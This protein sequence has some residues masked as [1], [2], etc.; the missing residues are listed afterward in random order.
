M[1]KL[2]LGLPLVAACENMNVPAQEAGEP[3]PSGITYEDYVADAG[4]EACTEDMAARLQLWV[5]G[6]LDTAVHKNL[7]ARLCDLD[8]TYYSDFDQDGY[9]ENADCDDKYNGFHPG[10]REVCDDGL[11]SDCDGDS[12]FDEPGCEWNSLCYPD[13]DGDGYVALSTPDGFLVKAVRPE[14]DA[15]PEGT[16][17][18]NHTR[19]TEDCDDAD[20][21]TYPGAQENFATY[22]DYNCDGKV[23]TLLGEVPEELPE[24]AIYKS[25]ASIESTENSPKDC[26]WTER[27]DGRYTASLAENSSAKNVYAHCGY[28]GERAN[29][30]ELLGD[31]LGDFVNVDGNS[32][33]VRLLGVENRHSPMNV[34]GFDSNEV[35]VTNKDLILNRLRGLYTA[36]EAVQ[37]AVYAWAFPRVADAFVSLDGKEQKAFYDVIDHAQDYL[38]TVDVAEETAWLEALRAATGKTGLTEMN[39]AEHLCDGLS[40]VSDCEYLFAHADRESQGWDK[41]RRAE[42]WV[43]R[44]LAEGHFNKEELADWGERF[45]RDLV[46]AVHESKSE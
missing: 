18:F 42:A 37:E 43:Y 38:E 8:G 6:P 2:L 33:V 26:I 27:E 17:F 3:L 1:K 41:M 46:M 30:N 5:E 14:E 9:L 25:S 22:K 4:V 19:D 15:C 7:A 16:K 35:E 24:F 34:F 11:D 13:A 29:W 45:E 20:I 40:Y 23:G 39:E 44:R 36:D 10:A 12:G 31:Y 32:E 21:V 28:P